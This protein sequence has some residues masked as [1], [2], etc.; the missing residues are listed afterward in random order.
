MNILYCMYINKLIHSFK[1]IKERETFGK[2]G[3]NQYGGLQLL[4][5]IHQMEQEVF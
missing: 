3:I 4:I 5:F 2:W 1:G